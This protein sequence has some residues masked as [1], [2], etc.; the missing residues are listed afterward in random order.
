MST[1]KVS[2]G[3][4]LKDGFAITSK[5]TQNGIEWLSEIESFYRERI[6]IEK[7]YSSKLRDLSKKYFEKKAKSSAQLSVGDKPQITPGSLESASLVLWNEVLTQ[8]EAISEERQKFGS[9]LT[10]EVCDNL[11]KLKFKCNNLAGQIG[12]VEHF[13]TSEF[14]KANEEIAKLKK[15]YDLT[16]QSTEGVRHKTEKSLSDK[17]QAKLQDKQTIMNNAKNEY[18]IKISVGNRLKDKYYYQDIPEILDY[19]QDLNESRVELL[20]KILKNALLLEK[21]RYDNI[22]GKLDTVE[23]VIA[24]NQPHL[25]SAMFVKHNIRDWSEPQDSYFIP[26]EFWHDDESL[27][28][29][30]PELTHLK[31][32]LKDASLAYSDNEKS[33]LDT[34][35]SIE[36]IALQIRDSKGKMTLLF[37]TAFNNALLLLLKFLKT[38]N[39]RVKN[40]VEIEIIQNFAGD[41]DLSYVEQRKEKKSVLSFLRGKKSS[42][43]KDGNKGDSVTT[44]PG[45]SGPKL[46]NSGLFNLRSD[47]QENAAEKGPTA[48]VIYPY[49]AD[50]NDELSV[51]TGDI[52]SVLQEDD[53]SGWTV[54]RLARNGMTGLVPTSYIKI[55]S[56]SPAAGKKQGPQVPP[57]R[58]AKKIQ[59]VEAL[60]NYDADGDDELTIRAGDRIILLTDNIE[61]SGWTEGELDGARGVFPTSYVKKI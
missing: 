46:L 6:S 48:T 57:K 52:V 36:R 2:F 60:Y 17:A 3:N 18:L 9:D 10:H 11:T 58:G 21:K 26:C 5:W 44:K 45:F 35:Q 51:D 59:Y 20:N 47:K 24:R 40:E 61:G 30:E 7:E 31:K 43:S 22:K 4:E 1:D 13:V 56:V 54:G 33:C 19:F 16:C 14:K 8:T 41:K 53:G 38:D 12:S 25:D 34:K 55:Q 39:L 50:G 32:L 37:D 15:H 49:D 28:T 27:V 42:E 29:K 23:D